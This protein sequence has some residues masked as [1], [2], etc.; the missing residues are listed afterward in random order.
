MALRN[1][2]LIPDPEECLSSSEIQDGIAP[3]WL[4]KSEAKKGAGIYPIGYQIR[5]RQKTEVYVIG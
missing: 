4:S 2:V 1:P 3:H 5:S